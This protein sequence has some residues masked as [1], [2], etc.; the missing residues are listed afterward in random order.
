MVCKSSRL[1]SAWR[2]INSSKRAPSCHR[3]K[4]GTHTKKRNILVHAGHK[5]LKCKQHLQSPTSKRFSIESLKLSVQWHDFTKF[6]TGLDKSLWIS[7]YTL[8]MQIFIDFHADAQQ[9]FTRRTP[10]TYL[11][12]RYFKLGLN[13]RM[14]KMIFLLIRWSKM[15]Q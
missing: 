2:A 14:W 12:L 3:L 6:L 4:K 9:F 5:Q 1:S 7:E 15:S 11:K 8:R 13:L 10:V